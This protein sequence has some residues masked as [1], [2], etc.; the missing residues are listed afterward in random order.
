MR[1]AIIVVTMLAATTPLE[2]AQSCMSKT[3]ARQHFGAVHIY[4]HGLD[5]CWD[6]TPGRHQIRRVQRRTPTD[7][8]RAKPDQ[9]KREEPKLDQSKLDQSKFDQSRF[10]Q[11]KWRDSMS[12]MLPDSDLAQALK[13]R[14]DAPRD[15][16]DN[17]ATAAPSTNRLV[18]LESSPLVSRWVDIAQVVPPPIIERRSEPLVAPRS[19]VL[20]LVAFVLIIGTVTIAFCV[21][22]YDRPRSTNI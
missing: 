7:E 2:A 3:E 22:V 8:A 20:I 15:E 21:M 13:A 18:D 1:V 16:N 9:P 11:S 5:H 17:A 4:W 6:A 14:R 19:A 12:E 10:D